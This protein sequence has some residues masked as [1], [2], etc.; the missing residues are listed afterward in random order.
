MKSLYAT[1]IVLALATSACAHAPRPYSFTAAAASDDLD[2]VA[3]TLEANGQKI[4]Q[5]D[6]AQGTI[7]TYWFD[8]GY[9]FREA[10][11]FAN[12]DRD[13]YTDIFLRYRVRVQKD[14]GQESVVVATDVQRC[15]PLDSHVTAA[16]VTG[17]CQPLDKIF[18]SQQ[19]QANALGNKLRQALAS[20][21]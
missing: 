7:T 21:S 17:T 6:Q 10:D 9:R 8:T 14:G 19:E 4:A 15:S 16:G 1:A 5:V 11:D 12:H 18:P 3:R 2:V 20:R 13:L